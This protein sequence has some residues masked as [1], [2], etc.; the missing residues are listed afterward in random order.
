MGGRVLRY[1]L[2]AV[3]YAGLIVYLSSLSHPEEMMPSVLEGLGDKVLHA[4]EYGLFGILWY[5][6]LRHAAGPW[7]ARY[8][9][10]LAILAAV[11]YGV[12]DELHQAFVPGREADA[13]DLLANGIGATVF[14]L[15]WHASWKR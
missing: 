6:A 14:T 11:V 7:A 3:A 15:V 9:L 12:T 5:R 10:G 1:W 4:V 2:P 13:W 8:A